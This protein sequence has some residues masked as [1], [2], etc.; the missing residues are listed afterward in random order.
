MPKTRLYTPGPTP[1][2]EEVQ[3]AI[4]APMDHHRTKG[5][6]QLLGEV[7]EGLQYVL[8]TK[9]TCLTFTSSGTGAMEGAIVCCALPGKKALVAHGGKFG[10]RWVDVCAA[11]GIA[12]VPIEVEW[13]KGVEPSVIAEHLKADPDIGMVITTHCETSTASITD[14]EAIAKIVRDTPAVYLVDAISSAGAVP[15]KTDQWGIDIVVTGSQK[16]L[17]TPPG[18]AFASVSAK[19]WKVI[20]SNKSPKAYYFDYRAYRKS[21]AKNDAPYTPALT[22]VR[23]VHQAL[24]MIRETGIENVFARTARLAKACRQAAKAMNLKLYSSHPSDSVT[25]MCVPDSIDEAAFRKTLRADFGVQVAGG[26]AQLKGKIFRITTMGFVDEV[27][28]IGCL[29]AVEKVLYDMGHKFEPGAG[30]AAAQKV[31]CE[32]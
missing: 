8:Q 14:I 17:M 32:G 29:S 21:L 2:S 27:D 12:C 31:F 13:G 1:V 16:A 20:E 3:L 6:Q 10:E 23:G 26:Q 4:A 7:T 24:K 9:N 15:I 25:A 19:A 30:L 5:Y 22:L 28:V 11:Y 18:L